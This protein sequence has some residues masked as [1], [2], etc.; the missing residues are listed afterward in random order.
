[1]KCVGCV[2]YWFSFTKEILES[3]RFESQNIAAFEHREAIPHQMYAKRQTQS[4]ISKREFMNLTFTSVD[5]KDAV[6]VES[7]R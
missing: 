3:F 2:A 6:K 1:M 5:N 7:N 4:N